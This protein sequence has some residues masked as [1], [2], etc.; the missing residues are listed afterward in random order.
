MNK[1]LRIIAVTLTVFVAVNVGN[2]FN[3]FDLGS[4]LLQSMMTTLFTSTY[5]T[6]TPLGSD[7]P[8][9]ADDRM[10]E[11]KSAVQERE[12]VDH[13]WPLTGTEVSDADTG[14]HRKVTLRVGSAPTAVADKGFVYAKD[15]TAKA[16]LHY[17]DEDDNEV[18][19]TA[20][21]LLNSAA[22]GGVT[23]DADT[24]LSAKAWF[25]D[26]DAMDDDDATKVASQQSIK[27]YVDAVVI[28]S[29]SGDSDSSTDSPVTTGN[30]KLAWGTS[31]SISANSSVTQAHGLTKC[32]S[33][34]PSQVNGSN[35]IS[36]VAIS[37]IDDTNITIHNTDGGAATTVR[38]FAIGR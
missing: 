35:D 6:N 32:F 38:W 30:F 29:V 34:W 21:G 14:E 18:Q 11:I 16:E 28:P 7:D 19:I 36:G 25:L 5:D 1:K 20:A 24:D 10:R 26:Q 2:A 23:L 37:I 33:A 15:V 12:N 27:A 9:E 13:Y 22:L 4:N 8:A 31:V 17:L 3:V